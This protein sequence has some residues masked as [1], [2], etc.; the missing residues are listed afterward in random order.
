MNKLI[1]A[2]A[3][4]L[5][6]VLGSTATAQTALQAVTL[7]NVRT[8]PGTGYTAIGQ[9]PA[10]HGY[11]GITRTSTGWWKIWYDGRAAY[12]YAPSWKTVAGTTGVKVTFDLL[13][14]RSGP[15]TSYSIV[16]KLYKGQIHRWSSYSGGWYR[17]WFGGTLR[18]VYGGG[19]TRVSLLGSSTTT[20]PPSNLTMTLYY[21]QTGYWCA[22]T[23]VQMMTKFFTGRV[24]SQSYLAGWLETTTKGTYTTH[25]L[26]GVRYF[27]GQDY[28]HASFSRARIVDN[29]QR[30]KPVPIGF[31]CRYV[32]YSRY[33]TARHVSPIKGFT[34]GGFYIN[35]S[36]WG[37][38][39]GSTTEFYNATLSTGGYALMVRY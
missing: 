2:I 35:D 34:S 8:G 3:T 17:I 28:K 6:T 21:Q 23:T 20:T 37:L 14:V 25:T 12:S 18:Y 15:G 10:G 31:E 30:S 1:G 27:T 9:V 32:A 24:Y 29:I 13:N 19:V 33:S 38:K 39:W 16:G 4:G 26:S 22:P 5:L 36:A 11:V 7:V